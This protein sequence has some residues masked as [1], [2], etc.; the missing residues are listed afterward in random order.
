MKPRL[1]LLLAALWWGSLTSLGFL[2]VPLL[3]T[4]M[5]GPAAAGAI[6]AKLFTGQTWLSVGC[7]M[8]LLMALNQKES[9]ATS[10]QAQTAIKFI[11]AGLFLAVLVEFGVAARIV[12]ARAEGGNL[13]LWHGIG[14]AMY[15]LQWVCAGMALWRLSGDT[16]TP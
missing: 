4:H 8:L 13:K 16:R 15:L 9:S 6:A 11:V 14:S 3:F 5:S 10:L 1:S 12:N 7:T 2:V